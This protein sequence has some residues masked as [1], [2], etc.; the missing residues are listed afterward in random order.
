[1]FFIT[2]TPVLGDLFVDGVRIGLSFTAAGLRLPAGPHVIRVTHEGYE[3]YQVIID[4]AP[5]DTVR[6]TRIGWNA[7][8]ERRRATAASSLRLSKI[9]T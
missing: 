4:V 5:G 9:K 8:V 7:P 6:K 1:M 3:P 2:T